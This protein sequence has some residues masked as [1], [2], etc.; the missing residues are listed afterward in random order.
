LQRDKETLSIHGINDCSN[1]NASGREVW[2]GLLKQHGTLPV[3]ALGFA[4]LAL[5]TAPVRGT[6]RT[7]LRS[8]ASFRFHS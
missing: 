5:K 2:K 1:F 7:F 4:A 8:A 6:G 3:L